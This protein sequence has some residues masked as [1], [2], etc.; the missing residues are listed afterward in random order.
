MPFSALTDYG[1]MPVVGKTKIDE[2]KTSVGVI[3]QKFHQ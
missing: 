3:F 2:E 1:Q